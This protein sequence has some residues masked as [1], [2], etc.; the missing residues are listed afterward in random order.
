MTLL[1]GALMVCLCGYAS[2]PALV[3]KLQKELDLARSDTAKIR[4]YLSLSD[5]ASTNKQRSGFAEAA[6]SLANVSNDSINISRASCKIAKICLL[7]ENFPRALTYGTNAEMHLPKWRKG[8]SDE[9]EI[10]SVMGDLYIYQSLYSQA[11]VYCDRLEQMGLMNGDQQL[12]AEAFDRKAL[13][14]KEKGD[15]NKALDAYSS[16]LSGYENLQNTEKVLAIYHSLEEIYRDLGFQ[17]KQLEYLL[18]HLKVAE[19]LGSPTLLTISYLRLIKFYNNR[20]ELKWVEKYLQLLLAIPDVGND[21][22]VAQNHGVYARDNK[23]Q[24]L[25][26]VYF[27]MGNKALA[28]EYQYKALEIVKK[29]GLPKRIATIHNNIAERY[30]KENKPDSVLYHAKLAYQTAAKLEDKRVQAVSGY[31]LARYYSSVKNYPQAVKY[32]EIVFNRASEVHYIELSRDAALLLT[33]CYEDLNQYANANKYIRVFHHLAD[34]ISALADSRMIANLAS[35]MEYQKR[36]E[37]LHAQLTIQ[38]QKTHSQ[39]WLNLL[40]LCVLLLFIVLSYTSWRSARAG[41]RNNQVLQESKEELETSNEELHATNEEL[42]AT[43]EELYATND[44]LSATQKELEKH[45]GHLEDLVLEKTAELTAALTQA[46]ESDRLKAAFFSNMSHELR[47]PLNAILGF[48]QFIDDPSADAEKRKE[49]IDLINANAN[50][51][52]TMVTDIIA[53]SSLDS[54]LLTITPSSVKIGDVLTEASIE[55]DRLIKYVGK[56]LELVTNNNLPEHLQTSPVLVDSER[57]KQVLLHLTDNAIKF[58]HKGYIVIGCEQD[59]NPALIRFWVEDT[60]IG[61]QEAHKELVFK[62]FWK[63]DQLHTQSYRGV[64]IGL[65][66]CEELVR[67]MGGAFLVESTPGEGSTFSFTVK[68]GQ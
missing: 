56:K 20:G 32:G 47:T 50:Q 18:K 41:K 22:Y 28:Y 40:M 33:N 48:L 59:E 30:I 57:I 34:S 8:T 45:R 27:N 39:R 3:G 68:Y 53:L 51:L 2:N 25:A 66:L 62:R 55:T 31:S 61:I 54:D 65:S 43:N 13:I 10:M 29:E 9:I 15:L 52:M 64:G 44:L 12:L 24:I 11:V 14:Y 63:H 1:I 16:A 7:D 38:R 58:T 35:Q 36:E 23:Y 5:H 49:M 19:S 60:G 21:I 4:L 46:Q 17:D 67:L 42:Y 6:C 37:S 26:D